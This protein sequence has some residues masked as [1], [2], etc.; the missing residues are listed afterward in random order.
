MGKKII[1]LVRAIIFNRWFIIAVVIILLLLPTILFAR[2]WCQ[3]IPGFSSTFQESVCTYLIEEKPVTDAT[4]LSFTQLFILAIL[5]S[6]WNLISGFTGYIDFGHAV[7]FGLGCFATALLMG[8]SRWEA[9]P[10][11]FSDWSF[12][13]AM[14]GGGVIAAIFA[15]IIGSATL[16]LKGPYFS[17]AM[18]GTLVAMREI[19]RTSSNISGGGLGLSLP[20]Y[21]N[22]PMFYYLSLI[23]LL[24]VVNFIRWL[25]S[26]EFGASL[27]AIR[28]DEV[29]AEMRGINT[30]LNKIT[31]FTIAA[32]LTGTVGG[33]WAYQNTFIDV[34][35]AF[36]Q[37]RTID[38]V[39]TTM[40][41]G[42]G[43]VAGPVIGSTIIYWLRDVL[44]ANFL[45]FHQIFEGLLLIIIVLFVPEGIMGLFN[46]ES[47]GTSLNR[48][49]KGWFKKEPEERPRTP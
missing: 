2:M 13:P 43:T 35:I 46:K 1:D 18:L 36:N 29:G 22:R 25:R 21:L 26:T 17:I 34:N 30:T 41:G 11:L 42:L 47:S 3:D 23:I 5:A 39:M 7:F 49:V 12:W 14:I 27:V 4:L 40:L 8:S 10:A 19:L 32:F 28:E 33:M 44:W 31:V 37:N 9:W 20:V 45:L 48:I 15:V 38:M 6:N 16:R 24:I